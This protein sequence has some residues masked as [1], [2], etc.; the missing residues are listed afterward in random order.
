ME[1]KIALY[2]EYPKRDMTKYGVVNYVCRSRTVSVF[3][4]TKEGLD[5]AIEQADRHDAMLV[6]IDQD[7]FDSDTLLEVVTKK[8]QEK[9]YVKVFAPT[10][11]IPER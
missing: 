5:A 6:K 11:Q 2:Q 10:G 3:P 4:A 8:I 9:R 1:P 7:Y